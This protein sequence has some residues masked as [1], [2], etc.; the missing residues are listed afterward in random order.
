ML[1]KKHIIL[2][3]L[4]CIFPCLADISSP[5]SFHFESL[6]SGPHI[7]S[8]ALP[9][10]IGTLAWLKSLLAHTSLHQ[11]P[12]LA[13]VITFEDKKAL[14]ASAAQELLGNVGADALPQ[15]NVPYYIQLAPLEVEYAKNKSLY[16]SVAHEF[17]TLLNNAVSQNTDN[18]PVASEIMLHDLTCHLDSRFT[19]KQWQAFNFKH[20]LDQVRNPHQHACHTLVANLRGSAIATKAESFCQKSLKAQ[21]ERI[22]YFARIKENHQKRA[23]EFDD[24]ILDKQRDICKAFRDGRKEAKVAELKDLNLQ[25]AQSRAFAQ[26]CEDEL[27]T[28]ELAYSRDIDAFV[29]AVH[30]ENIDAL[31]ADYASLQEN[32][33]QAFSHIKNG[34]AGEHIKQ[35][36][37]LARDALSVRVQDV[38]G[39]STA[40]QLPLNTDLSRQQTEHFQLSE[41]LLF[42]LHDACI[43]TVPFEECSGNA[44]QVCLARDMIK[45]LENARELYLCPSS[46]IEIKNC[47]LQTAHLV[48]IAWQE[49]KAGRLDLACAMHKL[50][51]TFF[52]YSKEISKGIGKGVIQ[53]GFRA[54]HLLTKAC[55]LIADFCSGAEGRQ[56]AYHEIAQG[57][58][59]LT[60]VIKGAAKLALDVAAEDC[61]NDMCITPEQRALF[62]RESTVG[63]MITAMLDALD[64]KTGPERAGAIAEIIAGG[65]TDGVIFG[66]ALKA[67][68]CACAT[69]AQQAQ[70]VGNVIKASELGQKAIQ[71]GEYAKTS[72]QGSLEYAQAQEA[73]VAAGQAIAELHPEQLRECSAMMLETMKEPIEGAR[74]A[75][76]AGE[77]VEKMP[78]SGGAEIK[79]AEEVP[80]SKTYKAAQVAKEELGANEIAVKQFWDNFERLGQAYGK[81]NVSEAVDVL[82]ITG[83]NIAKSSCKYGP[84]DLEFYSKALQKINSNPRWVKY[85]YDIARGGT[86]ST[87]SIEEALSAIACEEQ[88]LIVGLERSNI[89]EVDFI[90]N[91]KTGWDVKTPRSFAISGE[92]IF[93]VKSVVNSLKKKYLT[94]VG[95]IL[96]ISNLVPAHIQELFEAMSR[97]FNIDE[98]GRTIVV[99]IKDRMQSLSSDMV[100]KKLGK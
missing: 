67:G 40:H 94:G 60:T 45:L 52:S 35:K 97:E 42:F 7:S 90:Q 10:V 63:P 50:A 13:P 95:I 21:Q 57:A 9:K 3:L 18:S 30:R 61:A 41:E 37:T 84:A 38:L 62:M 92:K 27:R 64:K 72:L 69:V 56:K 14:V 53:S 20:Y 51:H 28:I 31:Y 86:I 70:K 46:G 43:S 85:K 77:A 34:R 78:I 23:K 8:P 49:N 89:P 5:P 80:Q 87:N 47:T 44:I 68:S 76:V 71:L 74:A 22:D 79:V 75:E 65:Y 98:F 96:D 81:E 11:Q 88:S 15:V 59:W 82:K 24:Q 36:L 17:A 55:S 6:S 2:T 29:A 12:V 26:S 73:A 1:H 16:D 25:Q 100:I 93:N 4:L 39:E 66:A 33:Q 91:G 19:D 58:R 48:N 32:Y 83:E 99:H 54:A